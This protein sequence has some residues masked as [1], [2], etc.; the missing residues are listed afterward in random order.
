MELDPAPDCEPPPRRS[1]GHSVASLPQRSRSLGP[2]LDVTQ[3]TFKASVEVTRS[4][5]LRGPGRG[6]RRPGPQ[7]PPADRAV[8]GALHARSEFDSTAPLKRSGSH[9]R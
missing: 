8:A 2:T 5:L 1:P 4:F 7:V 9:R 6:P 3:G